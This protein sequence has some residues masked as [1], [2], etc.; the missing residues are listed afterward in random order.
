MAL[1]KKI[2]QHVRTVSEGYEPLRISICRTLFSRLHESYVI[3]ELLY[4]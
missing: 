1:T 3:A 4:T 2:V